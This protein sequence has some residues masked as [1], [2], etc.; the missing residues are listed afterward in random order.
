MKQ[1][2]ALVEVLRDDECGDCAMSTVG[3][4]TKS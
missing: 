3:K 4:P 2:V 1:I